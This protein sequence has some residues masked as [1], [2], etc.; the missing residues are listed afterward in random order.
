M[1]A[2]EMFKIFQESGV[3]DGVVNLIT[4]SEPRPVGEEFVTNFS[5]KK[6]TFTGSTSTGRMLA[7]EAVKQIKRVS[8]ELGGLA[9]FIVLKDAYPVH[10]AKGA[11]LIKFLNNG[12]ACIS[13]NRIFV[14]ETK[15]REFLGELISRVKQMKVGNG[16]D[17]EVSVGPMVNGS[18]IERVERQVQDAVSK[19]ARILLGGHQLLGGVFCDEYFYAPTVFDCVS[20]DMLI[21]RE[22]TFGPVAPVI[23]YSDCDDLIATANDTTYGPVAYVY[24]GNMSSAFRY[25]EELNFGIIR[26]QRYKSHFCGS[27]FR[28]DE[29]VGSR[30]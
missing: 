23:T 25:F 16:L 8:M 27:T 28:W 10:A 24:T 26:Y 1:R 11:A 20:P 12:Q 2:I 19:G 14:H 17:E 5:V 13:P 4:T 3:P 7:Q 29:R 15:S 30:T 22:E 18:A 21:D 9:P 6:I